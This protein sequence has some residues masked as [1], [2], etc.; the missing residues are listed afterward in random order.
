MTAQDIITLICGIG[1]IGTLIV[2]L[3]QRHDNKKE[4]N[5]EIIERLDDIEHRQRRNEK[6]SVRIQLLLLMANYTSEDE[7]ELLTCAEHYFS[8]EHLHANWY[9]TSKFN[10]FIAEQEIAKPSWFNEE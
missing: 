3:I 9:M 1:W 10:R 2:F 7:H 5:N 8:K 6:D 4:K